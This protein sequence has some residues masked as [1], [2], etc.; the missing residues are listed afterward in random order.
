MLT[1]KDIE[2]AAK[3]H[4][5]AE[6]A[7]ETIARHIVKARRES[8]VH[9]EFR[10]SG[11]RFGTAAKLNEHDPDNEVSVDYPADTEVVAVE[12]FHARWSDSIEVVFPADYLDGTEG[13]VGREAAAIA[14]RKEDRK[15]QQDVQA[16]ID[17]EEAR[18]Q[19]RETYEH[20]RQE[21]GHDQIDPTQRTR[22]VDL[23]RET[24]AGHP[25][26]KDSPDLVLA[27]L[28]NRAELHATAVLVFAGETD[29]VPSAGVE[30][31]RV[32]TSEVG[33]LSS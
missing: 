27:W 29:V 17:D 13:Y 31:A 4:Q 12:L 7:L 5:A 30:P 10:L 19:R 16:E 8:D 28:A 14:A 18:S 21:F 24:L 3:E 25:H 23:A 1:R 2:R 11:Y 6:N 33:A 32:P 15:R 9:P 22:M 26:G 20:L